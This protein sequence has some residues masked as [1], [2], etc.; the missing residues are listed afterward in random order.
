[1][2][3][4]HYLT[5]IGIHDDKTGYTY[6]NQRDTTN[7]LNNIQ[8][9]KEYYEKQY[10]RLRELILDNDDLNQIKKIMYKEIVR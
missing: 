1:M 6:T 7:L 9:Q 10:W 4:F 2:S 8:D 3:R 5:G